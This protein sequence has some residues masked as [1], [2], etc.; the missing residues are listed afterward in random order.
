M[1]SSC[2]FVD[3]FPPNVLVAL[4]EAFSGK[5]RITSG[6]ANLDVIIGFQLF[7]GVESVVYTAGALKLVIFRT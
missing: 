5:E 1:V 7:E 6:D 2:H 3:T 4:C